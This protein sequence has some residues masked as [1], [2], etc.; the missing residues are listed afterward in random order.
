MPAIEEALIP[1]GKTGIQVSPLG[2]GAW[3]WGDKLFWA[4]GRAASAG[5]GFTDEDIHQAFNASL[6]AGVN[7]FDTAEVYG[8][9]RSE[10]LLGSFLPQAGRPVVVATKF[11]PLPWRLT[12]GALTRALRGSLKRMGLS[13]VDL[14]QVHWPF[15]LVSIETWAD[16]LADVVQAGLARSVGVSNYSEAQMRRAYSVLARRGVPLASNQVEYSLLNRTVE[17]NGLLQVCQELGI[18][19]I[20][21]SPLAQGALTGKYSPDRLM[22]GVRGRRYNRAYL[23]K[24]QPL[25]ALLQEIGRTHSIAGD[26]VSSSGPTPAQIALNWLICKGTLPI[27]GAK[28]AR[29]AL[30][31]C[32][33]LGWRLSESE[34]VALDQSSLGLQ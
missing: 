28:T 14:Y 5:G 29:Q 24:I 16:A 8:S 11:A 19:L 1:L 7:F 12:K 21:Y 18:T 20:A 3:A 17:L 10:R 33:A 6:D 15:K 26:A 4:Y 31:N 25:M 9:G 27:P 22:P 13:Q 23:E 32:G 2:I 34:V 30:D